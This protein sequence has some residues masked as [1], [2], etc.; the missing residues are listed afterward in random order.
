MR[1]MP[2]LPY[3][4]LATSYQHYSIMEHRDQEFTHA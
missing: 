2:P 3:L 4:H 1:K